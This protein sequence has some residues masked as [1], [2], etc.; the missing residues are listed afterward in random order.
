ML[1]LNSS[2]CGCC[3][4]P[5]G[6]AGGGGRGR[7]ERS[8]CE[9]QVQP[10]TGRVLPVVARHG[11]HVERRDGYEHDLSTHK[12]NPVAHIWAFYLLLFYYLSLATLISKAR[13]VF[14]WRAGHNFSPVKFTA[15]A[16][17]LR[18]NHRGGYVRTYVG[19]F[20]RAVHQASRCRNIFAIAT[21]NF[22][23]FIIL[24]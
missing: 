2:C 8:I 22:S 20:S 7:G 1:K 9:R 5:M 21:A 12:R 16:N 13:L 11:M 15:L 17:R 4:S 18:Q 3:F 14:V 6:A 10:G 19:R 24:I 23:R